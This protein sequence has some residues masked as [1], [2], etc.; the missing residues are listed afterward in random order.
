[1]QTRQRPSVDRLKAHKPLNS[2][3]SWPPPMAECHKIPPPP[4][5]Q[6]VSGLSLLTGD[7]IAI[8]VRGTSTPVCPV[9]L[10]QQ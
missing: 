3:R 4:S 6:I 9:T 7:I 5:S 8:R 10:V 2:A 1:M